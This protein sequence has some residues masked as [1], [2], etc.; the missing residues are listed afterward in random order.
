MQIR[1]ALSVLGLTALLAAASAGAT[2]RMVEQAIETST[3]MT[4]LPDD[5]GGSL[6]VS[7][8]AGCKPVLLQLSSKSQ[9]FIGKTP[10]T[11]A[12]LRAAANGS[13]RQLNVFYQAKDRTITRLVVSGGQ[14]APLRRPH[15]D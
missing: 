7:S 1:I 12:E 9:Y 14:S 8:C 15:K 5:A 4:S 6:A 11:Y 2:L 13:S 10:V 3:L